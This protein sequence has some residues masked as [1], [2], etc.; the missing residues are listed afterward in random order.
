MRGIRIDAV[1]SELEG[2]LDLRGFLGLDPTVPKGYT[3]IRARFRVQADSKDLPQIRELAQFSPVFNTLANGTMVDVMV[4]PAWRITRPGVA[5]RSSGRS[6][7]LPRKRIGK[8]S[9]PTRSVC[10]ASNDAR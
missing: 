9:A 5:P 6:C 1:E 3:A 10:S 4:D 8:R 2:D 7:T